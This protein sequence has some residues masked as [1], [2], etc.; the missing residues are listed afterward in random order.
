VLTVT[1]TNWSGAVYH[2]TTAVLEPTATF[3]GR[4]LNQIAVPGSTT[5][6]LPQPTPIQPGRSVG[7]RVA[8]ALPRPTGEL[9]LAIR[10]APDAAQAV[11]GGQT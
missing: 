5:V 3:D 2:P 11:I 8:Y 4:P 9:R 6:S 7:Y 10:A 1:I